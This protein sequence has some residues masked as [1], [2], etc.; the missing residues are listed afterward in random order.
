MLVIARTN[1]A[2]R[3]PGC[4]DMIFNAKRRA[5]TRAATGGKIGGQPPEEPGSGNGGEHLEQWRFL[6][7]LRGPFSR[8]ATRCALD[9]GA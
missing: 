2:I 9:D 5:E 4:T 7:D 1:I 3:L 6:A 8:H